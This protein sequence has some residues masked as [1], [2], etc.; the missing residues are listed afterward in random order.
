MAARYYRTTVGIA[1]PSLQ[2]ITPCKVSRRARAHQ[3]TMEM[4]MNAKITTLASW[5]FKTKK[6]S[7]TRTEK[8]VAKV[9]LSACDLTLRGAVAATA[10]FC[11]P[12]AAPGSSGP[13]GISGKAAEPEKA[14]TAGKTGK[15]DPKEQRKP[16]APPSFG[17]RFM[18]KT[19]RLLIEVLLLV[20]FLTWW[21]F[22]Y[23]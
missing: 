5:L 11:P 17:M 13:A 16:N 14:T 8:L 10:G 20:L 1:Y 2:G 22:K 9:L 23:H 18:I 6:R 4:Q 21:R 7:A 12:E 3:R 15:E 19:R